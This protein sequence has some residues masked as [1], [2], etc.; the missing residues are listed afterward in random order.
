MSKKLLQAT[1][2]ILIICLISGC[3][4]DR[5]AG[6]TDTKEE[7]EARQE[8]SAAETLPDETGGAGGESYA[9]I[10]SESASEQE[11][12]ETEETETEETTEEE[13]KSPN[14]GKMALASVEAYV[15]VRQGPGV[16]YDVVGKIYNDC[17]AYIIDE[18]EEE[19]G[20]W[21]LISSGQVIGYIKSEFFLVG[22]EADVKLEEV[23][24]KTGIVMEDY[25]R[26]RSEPDLSN[27]DNVFTFYE[28]GT[29]VYI[30][31]LTEDG[32][33]KIKSDDASS[34][35]VYAEC[36]DLRTE[37][38]TAITLKEEADEIARR[39][40]A[41]EA[42]RRAQE[43]Y[44]AALAAEEAARERARAAQ[45]EANRQAQESGQEAA[46]EAARAAAE[47]AQAEA[48]AVDDQAA[49]QRNAVVAYALQFV[50]NPYV[51]GGRSL[52]TGTDCS[53]FTHLVY[54]NFGY[55]LDYT[56]A[57]QSNQGVPV[58]LSALQ[59]G[60]LLF[61]S[62]S[63]KYLGHVAMYIGNGQIVHAGTVETGIIVGS[64][65]YRDPLFARRIIP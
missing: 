63:Q 42:A 57:G 7:T 28:K 9:E 58:D 43:E 17:A 35:F 10:V 39:E 41:E 34:G 2:I 19:D 65:Y 38:R 20:S 8:T 33:A 36:L 15:N 50:G 46:A 29:K 12:T 1:V 21:F 13:T 47:A 64:A 49:A 32:W 18:M 4:T 45:E 56:P 37:F 23:G 52:I 48:A 51:H 24:V 5:S 40:A 44:E 60:D 59:P 53:G 25:L 62:N 31:E 30:E 3:A 27:P 22:E 16:D 6:E 55:W 11:L 26:V 61:Y 54:E 14:I